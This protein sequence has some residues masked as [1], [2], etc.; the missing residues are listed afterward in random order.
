MNSFILFLLKS[1]TLLKI[2]LFLEYSC[3]GIQ[4]LALIFIGYESLLP[5]FLVCLYIARTWWFYLSTKTLKN[6]YRLIKQPIFASSLQFRLGCREF[7]GP[8]VDFILSSNVAK[9]LSTLSCLRWKAGQIMI[10]V[11]RRNDSI[12]F[13]LA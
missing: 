13:W 12:Y 10:I 7:H 2:F 8:K 6:C 1:Q 4:R 3:N 9:S 5:A 11:I